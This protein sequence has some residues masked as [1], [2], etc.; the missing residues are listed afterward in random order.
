MSAVTMQL[1]HCINNEVGS[2]CL[3]Y[4]A[5]EPKIYYMI[6]QASLKWKFQKSV[7]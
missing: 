3:L 4:S 1:L 2:I 7:L 5:A 6:M